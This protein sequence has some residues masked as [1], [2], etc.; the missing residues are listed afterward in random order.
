MCSREHT[1]QACVFYRTH[2]L[3]SIHLDIL[4]PHSAS[5]I[6]TMSI[7]AAPHAGV[8]WDQ[9]MVE[10]TGKI[11]F[12]F[13]WGIIQGAISMSLDKFIFSLPFPVICRLNLSTKRKA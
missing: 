5:S 6:I 12:T 7:F 11:P 3:L 13:Y 8:T 4:N 1:I 2:T 10:F 9:H